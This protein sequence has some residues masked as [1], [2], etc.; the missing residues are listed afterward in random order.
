MDLD[1][2]FLTTKE[3]LVLIMGVMALPAKELGAKRDITVSFFPN[4]M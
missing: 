3:R 1:T 2:R 4:L